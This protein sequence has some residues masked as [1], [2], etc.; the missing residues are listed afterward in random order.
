MVALALVATTAFGA[1][2]GWLGLSYLG[3]LSTDPKVRAELVTLGDSLGPGSDVKFRGIIVGR[4][5]RLHA[6]DS[7]GTD[8]GADLLLR[9]EQVAQIP[10]GVTARV[11]PNTLFGSEYVELVPPRRPTGTS[12]AAGDVVRADTS[13]ATVR[14]MGAF[15]AIERLLVAVD[16]AQ[17]D[18]AIS[19]LAQALD[20]RG[21]DL[22]GFVRRADRLVGAMATHEPTFYRDLALLDQAL[23]TATDLEPELVATL[24]SSVV[25]A[26]TLVARQRDIAQLVA[27]GTVLAARG[28]ALLDR[29]EDRI[30]RLL[31]ATGPTVAAF[32]RNTGSLDKLLA[33]VP[34]V[35]GNGASSIKGSRIMMEGLIGTNPM[36]PYTAA[37]CPRYDGVAGSNCAGSDGR[38]RA[39]D[40]SGGVDYSASSLGGSSGPVGSAQEQAAVAA[41]FALDPADAD[42]TTAY[43]LLAGPL[44]RG[45]E[46]GS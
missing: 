19:N 35:L 5:Q 38:Y 2:A 9:P 21:D 39:Y 41:A 8:P 44:L 43:T 7:P 28:D 17:L 15:D 40:R 29:E 42:L 33:G 31:R 22:G 4:V 26:R 32:S 10:S 20:G 45:T 3:V 1:V 25:T 30:I 12:I 6:A 24:R 23:G 27:G 37:D 18:L 36:D 14:L 16:P 34:G 46:V 13:R 11:L